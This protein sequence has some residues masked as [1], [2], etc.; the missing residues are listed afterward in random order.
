M[1]NKITSEEELNDI[2][3]RVAGEVREAVEFA[4]NSP[5]PTPES[6]FDYVYVRVNRQ[7]QKRNYT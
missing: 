7:D 5:E 3:I 6:L 4:E 2:D 1:S